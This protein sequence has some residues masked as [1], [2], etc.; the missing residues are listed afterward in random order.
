MSA[1]DTG[2]A[3]VPLHEQM[4]SCLAHYEHLATVAHEWNNQVPQAIR[5]WY[6]A[7]ATPS[8]TRANEGCSACGR[9]AA[10]R[11]ECTD[12]RCMLAED[13]RQET[14]SAIGEK[15]RIDDELSLMG[16]IHKP[17]QDSVG[18][19]KEC[20]YKT[21]ERDHDKNESASDRMKLASFD[22]KYAGFAA[23]PLNMALEEIERLEARLSATRANIPAALFDGYAVYEA[24]GKPEDVSPHNVA[25]VLDAVVRL[26]R[27]E[28]K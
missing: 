11:V 4:E 28:G 27:A 15:K 5:A 17:G 22:A 21:G 26:I 23:V 13:I 1:G 8:E 10:Q 6:A 2:A 16:Y 9:S 7:K 24:M 20:A 25:A 14:R 18:S 3:Q 12:E 19:F